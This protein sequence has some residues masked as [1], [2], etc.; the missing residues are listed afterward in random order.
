MLIT[1]DNRTIELS[2]HQIDSFHALTRLQQGV[3]LG[4]LE[5]LSQREAYRRAGG[6]AKSDNVADQQASRMVRFD[7]VASFINS[8]KSDQTNRLADAIMS[9]DDMAL[10]LN[11]MALAKVTVADL[12]NPDK[13]ADVAEVIVDPE[14]GIRYKLTSPADRR[15]AMKQLAELMGYN[16]P[17]ELKLSGELTTRARLDDFYGSNS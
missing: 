13:L 12:D 16:K 1:I 2:D 3:A 6:K 7:K 15:A 10:A 11:N 5:G 9:R 8:F 4:V 17:T 14:G